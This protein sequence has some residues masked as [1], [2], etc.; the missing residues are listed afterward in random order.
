MNRERIEIAVVRH[1][2][3]ANNNEGRFCGSTDYPLSESGRE[4]IVK[5]LAKHPYPKVEKLFCSPAARAVQ[6][7]ELC[8]PGM[9]YTLRD[10]LR[11]FY[12]GDFEEKSWDLADSIPEIS[13]GWNHQLWEF[14]FPGGETMADCRDRGI[15]AFRG[16]IKYCEENSIKKAAVVTHSV[17]MVLALR[18]LIKGVPP[19]CL[20]R[21]CP[22]GMGMDL[23]VDPGQSEAERPFT[24]RGWLPEG[25]EMPGNESSLYIRD[26]R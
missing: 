25:V 9:D 21:Y 3:T 10:D 12:F 15:S 5:M 16:I 22:N 17:L 7:A 4:K 23:A 1:G 19:G 18:Q 6:T 8:F 14:A 13:Y 26:I 20:V 2:F 11:E 24:F